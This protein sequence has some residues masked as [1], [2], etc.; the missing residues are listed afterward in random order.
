MRMLSVE[1]RAV[2][3]YVNLVDFEKIDAEK[4]MFN[5]KKPVLVQPQPRMSLRRSDVM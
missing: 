5:C 4:C 3:K 2:G 1:F